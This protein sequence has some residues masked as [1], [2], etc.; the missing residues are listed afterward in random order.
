MVKPTSAATSNAAAINSVIRL[1]P[2]DVTIAIANQR[3]GLDP[4]PASDP[5]LVDTVPGDRGTRR[6]LCQPR[7]LPIDT[8]TNLV[9][10]PVLTRIRTS[11]LP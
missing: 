3:D 11:C 5:L 4:V 1:N 6:V 7:F 2:C 8:A 9:A 10:S